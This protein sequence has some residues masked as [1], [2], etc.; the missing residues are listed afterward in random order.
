MSTRKEEEMGQT[1]TSST[2]ASASV[3]HANEQAML[4]KRHVIDDEIEFISSN[5]VKKMRLTEQKHDQAPQEPTK[6]PLLNPPPPPPPPPPPS[7]SPALVPLPPPAPSQPPSCPPPLPQATLVANPTTPAP[8]QTLDRR[9]SMCD[10]N[11]VKAPGPDSTLETRGNSLPVFKK[12]F[13]SQ[14]PA[15]AQTRPPRH[16]EAISPKQLPQTYRAPPDADANTAHST[17]QTPSPSSTNSVTLDQISCLDFNGTPTNSP[18]FD[19]SQVF[20][21][22]GGIMGSVG[23][24][25]AVS[26]THAPAPI[27]PTNTQ[28]LVP[29]MTHLSSEDSLALPMATLQKQHT[30][31]RHLPSRHES[32]V[33]RQPSPMP[34]TKNTV[35]PPCLHCARIRFIQ[36]STNHQLNFNPPLG[37]VHNHN[38]NNGA[39]P[40]PAA[41][42]HPA[43]T[44]H[45]TPSPHPAN[46]PR[47][48]HQQ[49]RHQQH[50]HH[51]QSSTTQSPSLL[52]TLP[53]KNTPSGGPNPLLQDM[54]QAIQA[55]F[56][57]TQVAARQGMAPETVAEVLSSLVV[58]PLLLRSGGGHGGGGGRFSG[59]PPRSS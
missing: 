47:R 1:K 58:V 49:Q 30:T 28:N 13:F 34:A 56:P 6:P 37:L 41:P 46:H 27:N 20:S 9:R 50:D 29:P 8:T 2:S 25:N 32:T 53:N 11:Q 45:P 36:N 24:G 5:P 10:A 59:L 52:H 44:S 38:N 33:A 43:P 18:G 48:H 35:K 40:H 54:A 19:V 15:P 57:Y 12:F 42:T 23:F 55:S 21:A 4:T 7:P 26:Q 17:L 16:S 14:S 3:G 31:K 39:I 22:D 51:L